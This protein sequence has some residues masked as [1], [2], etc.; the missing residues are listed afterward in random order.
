MTMDITIGSNKDL[1]AQFTDQVAKQPDAVA[2][3]TPDG[4]LSYAELQQQSDRI[5]S[6]LQG[7]GV[8]AGTDDGCRLV[9][10]CMAR[11]VDAICAMLGILK[12]G[13]A[14]LP[15]DPTY[16]ADLQQRMVRSAGLRLHTGSIHGFGR[17]CVDGARLVSAGSA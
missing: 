7:L 10:L 14:Y 16:P 17:T 5:A 11:G 3:L 13:G 4:T 9:G 6:A 15:I 1:L 2:L 12:A 8:G